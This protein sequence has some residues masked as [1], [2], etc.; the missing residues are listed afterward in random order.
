VYL[1][2]LTMRGFRVSANE[3]LDVV[4][5]GRFSVLVGANSVGK[6]TIAEG[7]CLS[8]PRRFP[9]LA[10]PSSA[11]LGPP[12]RR[13][14]VEYTL[15][16]DPTTESD[17]GRSLAFSSGRWPGQQA[18]DWTYRLNR[19]LGSVRAEAEVQ[20]A[21]S[22]DSFPLLYLPAWR[23]PIDELAR[24]DTVIL[25]QL[26]RAQQQQRTGGRDLTDLRVR[27]SALLEQLAADGLLTDVEQRI[28]GHLAALS[29]GVSRQWAYVRGQVADD[30]YLARVLQFMLATMEGRTNALPLDVSGLGYVNL[31]HIAITLAAIPDLT[32]P[33]MPAAPGAGATAA[34]VPPLPPFLT[35][36]PHA[37]ADGLPPGPPLIPGQPTPA[38]ERQDLSATAERARRRME[39]T[40]AESESAEDSFFSTDAF[41]ATVVIEEPEAHL[42]PQ[43]QHAL[44]RYLREVV[45]RRPELQIILSSHATDVITSCL[46]EE[47]VV[48]RQAAPGRRVTRP[49]A[50]LPLPPAEKARVLRM[51]RLHLDS[52]RSSA[53]FAER[54]VLVE[55]VTD[56]AV[57]R[58]FGRVWAGTDA[59]RAA[60]IDALS[61][62]PMGTKVGDWSVRLLATRGY[63]MCRRVAILRDSDQPF[64]QAPT[65]PAWMGDFD[66]D[67]ARMFLSHPTLEPAITPGNEQ[68]INLAI[69]ALGQ[70]ALPLVTPDII[71]V[72]FGTDQGGGLKK[73]KAEFALALADHLQQAREAGAW[74]FVPPHFRALFDYLYEGHLPPDEA[75][76]TTGPMQ[77]PGPTPP[78]LIDLNRFGTSTP[79][80]SPPVDPDPSGA[81]T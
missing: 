28:G 55:G 26:L 62:V 67:T 64:S 43:L 60:F 2:R 1:S 56:A 19:R 80:G 78:P 45:R 49:I 30:V 16:P 5:P 50:H 65:L 22:L 41:H 24:R 23:N 81:S 11:A 68:L 73:R 25:L 69:T 74:I 79:T 46:P 17:L 71:H 33:A 18:A 47:V 27:A 39:Q 3:D 35:Q 13:I 53:L 54:L 21:V 36:V 77:N 57:V 32:Q 52:T 63:E 51:T 76:A 6:T 38:D 10:P 7:L 59:G 8:H 14:S 31:L 48:V 61:I 12:P 9:A 58:E 75:G 40:G 72:A 37:G 42:H 70:P 29:A 34:P 66:P 15:N 44:V 4:I 20:P